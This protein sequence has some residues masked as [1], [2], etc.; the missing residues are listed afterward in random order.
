MTMPSPAEVVDDQIANDRPGA[1]WTDGEA[2]MGPDVRWSARSVQL[3][4][5]GAAIDDHP[6]SDGRQRRARC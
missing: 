4:P 2:I 1:A 6:F 5:P 3:D